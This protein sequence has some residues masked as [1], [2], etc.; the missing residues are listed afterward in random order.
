MKQ[1]TL[2]LLFGCACLTDCL[3]A[4]TFDGTPGISAPPST[5]GSYSMTPFALNNADPPP[6]SSSL[7]PVSSPLGGTLSFGVGLEHRRA[8]PSGPYTGWGGSVGWG[9]GYSGDVYYGSSLFTG[10]LTLTLPPGT[11]AFYFYLQPE[12]D[13]SVINFA[14]LTSDG[15]SSGIVPVDGRANARYFGFYETTPGVSLGS[16]SIS[17]PNGSPNG[18]AIGEFGIAAVPEPSILALGATAMLL[19]FARRFSGKF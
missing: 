6:G 1:L 4:A 7:T 17:A 18:F 8:G 3:A 10:S 16:I 9:Q 13:T 14:A 11:G 2:T 12:D 15:G 19:V 5:L